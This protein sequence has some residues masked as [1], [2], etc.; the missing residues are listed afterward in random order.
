MVWYLKD[1]GDWACAG[2]IRRKRYK[3]FRIRRGCFMVVDGL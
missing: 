1:W 2:L 3:R